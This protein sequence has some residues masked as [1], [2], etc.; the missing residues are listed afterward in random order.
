MTTLTPLSEDRVEA[1][2]REQLHLI[3]PLT[4]LYHRFARAIEA[5]LQSQLNQPVLSGSQDNQGGE[6]VVSA[7][8]KLVPI[9]PTKEMLMAAVKCRHGDAT[10]KVTPA[11]IEEEDAADDYAAILAA[12]PEQHNYWWRN[13]RPDVS[14]ERV[15]RAIKAA[16][17]DQP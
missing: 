8:W 12:V 6:A 7:R 11:T 4:N 15:L 13:G 9:E 3:V 14:E 16:L 5:E 1:I 10:Y 2:Y 17:G